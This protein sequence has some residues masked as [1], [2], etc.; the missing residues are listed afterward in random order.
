MKFLEE[1]A[2][3]F[4]VDGRSGQWI[5]AATE[6][7]V[8]NGIGL[9]SFSSAIFNA[10][11]HGREKIEMYIFMVQLIQVKPSISTQAKMKYECFKI[12]AAGTFAWLGIENAEVVWLNDFC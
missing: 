1:S 12:P 2:A 9:K 3:S 7:L 8:N 11:K 6:I 10:V 5:S 4:C